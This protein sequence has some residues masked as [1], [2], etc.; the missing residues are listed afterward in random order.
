MVQGHNCGGHLDANGVVNASYW[1]ALERAEPPP[2]SDMPSSSAER[3]LPRRRATN[4]NFASNAAN[5]GSRVLVAFQGDRPLLFGS[6][7]LVKSAV[8]DVVDPDDE[9]ACLLKFRMEQALSC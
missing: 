7:S 3:P 5:V 1:G 6:A 4:R 2:T 9:I 8:S